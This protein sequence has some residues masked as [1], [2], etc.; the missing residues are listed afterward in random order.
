M[1]ST[2]NRGK[3]NKRIIYVY[4]IKLYVVYV[5]SA[6]YIII[7]ITGFVF[8]HQFTAAVPKLRTSD[9]LKNYLL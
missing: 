7:V 2:A 3:R 4:V 5:Y 6:R 8:E 1:L 9:S